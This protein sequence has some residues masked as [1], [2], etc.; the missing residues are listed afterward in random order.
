MNDHSPL[1]SMESRNED[2]LQERKEIFRSRFLLGM[3]LI[4]VM[5]SVVAVYYRVFIRRDYEVSFE[6]PCN[7]EISSCFARPVCDTDDGLCSSGGNLIE[8][9]Y[10]LVV[11]R[12]A[13]RLLSDCG[14]R[15]LSDLS[16]ERALCDIGEKDCEEIF[17]SPELVPEGES[18]IGPGV[19]PSVRGSEGSI[20]RAL[21]GENF[22]AR[23]D[24]Q[25][26][27]ENS[28]PSMKSETEIAPGGEFPRE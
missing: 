21:E 14:E 20:P 10:Y 2:E 3:L 4:V 18:C 26:P 15:S 13:G 16:C 28:N 9:N 6:F 24:K 11:H 27:L 19:T 8:T 23:S 17:C 7:P 5:L 12:I 22:N 25:I 1:K